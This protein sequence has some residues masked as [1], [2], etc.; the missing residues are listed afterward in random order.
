M[1]PEVGHL[2]PALQLA[3]WIRD[4][5]GE[6]VF[7]APPDFEELI[8][9]EQLGHVS[10]IA[11][12]AQKGYFD[13]WARACRARARDD[14]VRVPPSLRTLLFAFVASSN[15]GRSR[16][17]PICCAWTSSGRSCSSHERL[18]LPAILLETDVV[19]RV[20]RFA[21]PGSGVRDGSTHDDRGPIVDAIP[22]LYGTP[23]RR[24]RG[25]VLL[26]RARARAAARRERTVSH[27]AHFSDQY[28]PDPRRRSFRGNGWRQ[29][30][31]GHVTGNKHSSHKSAEHVLMTTARGYCARR[32]G[33]ARC[34]RRWPRERGRSTALPKGSI[35]DA[36]HSSGS[37]ASCG[38]RVAGG[39]GAIRK[40][41][42]SVAGDRISDD[43]SSAS[44]R[45]W[46]AAIPRD[47]GERRA[48]PTPASRRIRADLAGR[49]SRGA[50][51]ARA[52]IAMDGFRHGSPFCDR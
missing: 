12:P 34:A 25:P 43:R 19:R 4:S 40:R 47:R 8:A 20:S 31:R 13:A 9:R 3:K 14:S 28:R 23:G 29:T 7:L 35:L 44:M 33:S 26:S 38:L 15:A 24:R 37:R 52:R 32:E 21:P 36:C 49:V 42:T 30:H 51:G 46:S 1:H 39:L 2:L 16:A 10:I 6:V 50:R 45:R 18:D 48:S 27:R 11:P 5:G 17:Y 41:F 22:R